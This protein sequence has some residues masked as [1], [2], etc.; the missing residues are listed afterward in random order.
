[1]DIKSELILRAISAFNINCI[2]E[3]TYKMLKSVASDESIRL[4]LRKLEQDNII[5]NLGRNGFAFRYKLNSIL[6]CPSFIFD[7]RISY[8]VKQNI[9][10]LYNNPQEYY[11]KSDL[12]RIWNCG[13]STV[14]SRKDRLKQAVNM[15]L[16]EYMS[17]VTIITK[18]FSSEYEVIDTLE[19]KQF[20]T[21]LTSTNYKCRIC[22]EGN[23]IKF[24]IRDHSICKKCK[25]EKEQEK[26]KNLST[27]Q[28]LYKHGQRSKTGRKTKEGFNLTLEEIE[29]L[30][31]RQDYKC[32]YTGFD[33]SKTKYTET[34]KLDKPTLD[35]ID[36]SKGYTLDNCVICT[37]WSNSSKAELSKEDFIKLCKQ[38]AN[39]FPDN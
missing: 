18:T 8:I 23:S 16:N 30:L 27:A 20:R 12:A 22:G 10:Q 1:M 33:F 36:S 11:T 31:N 35:R 21:N 2:S 7:K 14:Y 38:V 6:D 13:D 29:T 26:N 9:L 4:E 32:Y 39:N 34:S 19:G 25:R 5:E 37:W 3:F 24:S 17:N 28:Q 15:E